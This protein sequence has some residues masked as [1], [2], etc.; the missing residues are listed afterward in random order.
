MCFVLPDQCKADFML[1]GSYWR[2]KVDQTNV[3]E[4]AVF[5]YSE[6]VIFYLRD[7]WIYGYSESKAAKD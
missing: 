3:R 5:L 1:L 2:E 6:G 7:V 4:C